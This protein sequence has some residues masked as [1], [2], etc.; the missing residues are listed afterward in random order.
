MTPWLTA[1]IHRS[2]PTFPIP[3]T[4]QSVTYCLQVHVNSTLSTS[5]FLAVPCVDDE[6]E[7]E[8]NDDAPLVTAFCAAPE[9]S[10]PGTCPGGGGSGDG[11]EWHAFGNKCFAVMGDCEG[12]AVPASL[13]TPELD[14]FATWLLH[15]NLPSGIFVLDLVTNPAY[16]NYHQ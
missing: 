9:S 1:A 7:E 11:V 15:L 5:P 10:F 3:P 16:Y 8:T 12:D 2:H 6:D 13:K 14:A 4:N